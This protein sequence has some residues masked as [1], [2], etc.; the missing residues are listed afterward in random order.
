MSTPTSAI[1]IAAS[2]VAW[3][4]DFADA[5]T[6]PAWEQVLDDIESSGVDAL[7]IGP[8]GYLPEDP[9]TLRRVLTSRNLTSV[10]SF[11]FDDLHDPKERDRVLVLSERIGTFIAAGGG[12]VF[13]IIDKPDAIRAGTA[14]RSHSAPRLDD[15]G[16]AQMLERFREIAEIARRHGVSPVAHPHVG[17]YVEFADEIERLVAETDLDLCLDTGH[18]AYARVDPAETI[19]RYGERLGH[20]HFKD[21]RPDVL[22]RVDAEGLTFWEAIKADIFCPLGEGMVDLRDVYDA[23]DAVG[24]TGYATIEQDRVGGTGAPLDDLYKSLAVI[25][26]ARAGRAQ[27]VVR[28]DGN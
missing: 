7:E 24:Y 4:I 13:V 17:G 15:D 20:V 8:V 19:R 5:P 10:G 14:G 3:G 9:D 18:L 28:G 12:G 11:I 2:P 25:D 6:N 21:I 22:A 16:W 27:S 26:A 1:K 23:L